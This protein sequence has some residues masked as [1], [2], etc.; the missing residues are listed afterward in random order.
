MTELTK[1]EEQPTQAAE[2]AR[3]AAQAE[4]VER[5][6]HALDNRRVRTDADGVDPAPEPAE[7]P[8]PKPP[9][10]VDSAAEYAKAREEALKHHPR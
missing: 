5:S 8:P 1:P 9:E 2:L 3:A 6:R 4:A 10:P 7:A